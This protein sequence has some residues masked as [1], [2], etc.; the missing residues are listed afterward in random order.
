MFE[1]ILNL[2]RKKQESKS[3]ES[4]R[5]QEVKIISDREDLNISD[6]KFIA[7]YGPVI[8]KAFFEENARYAEIENEL[9]RAGEKP[10]AAGGRVSIY[11]GARNFLPNLNAPVPTNF[12]FKALQFLQN[13]SI[14]NPHISMAVENVVA[15]GNTDYKIDFGEIGEGQSTALRKL[16][17]KDVP[18][19]YEFSDGE[20][21]MDNDI[22]TQLAITGTISAESVIKKDLRGI[23]NIVRVDPYY[24]RF[25]YDPE[26]AVHIPLQEIGG[27]MN[28]INMTNT[29]YPGY[30]ELNPYTYFY[31]AM[32]R[33][34]EM[35]YAIPPFMAAIESILIEN[36]MIKNLQNMMR[37]LGM[38]GFLSV[39]VN[40]PPQRQGEN[41]STYNGRL[42]SYLEKLRPTV[43]KGFHR[44][45][46][47]GF[48]D[49]HEFKVHSPMNPAAAENTLKMVKSLIYAGVKQDPNMHGENYSV[50]ET[51][52]RVI[53]EKMTQQV[54]NYQRVLGTFKSKI[55]K[56]HLWLN[57]KFV[58][59]VNVKYDRS[60]VHD[61]KR[62]QEVLTQKITNTGLLYQAGIIDQTKRA[63]M[64]G[65]DEAA[66]DQPLE[67]DLLKI[68]KLKPQP[69][70]S[71]KKSNSKRIEEL[72]K[73]L[74]AS[75]PEFNY[76]VPEE[77]S[78]LSLVKSSDFHDKKLNKFLKTYLTAVNKQFVEAIDNAKPSIERELNRL[79][80]D[81][82]LSQVQ[83]AVIYG[84]FSKWDYN[85]IDP[86]TSIVQDNIPAIYS[87]FRKDKSVFKPEEGFSRESLFV[88]PD[89]IFELHD[90]RAIELL[91][92]I[93]RIYLGKFITDADTEK[94]FMKWIKEK[95]ESGDVPIGKNSSLISEFI[96]QFADTV[97]LEAWKIRRIIETTVNRTRNTG[98]V[99]YLNQAQ[100]IEYE[101]V[102]VMDDITCSWCKHMNSKKFSVKQSVDKYQKL[103]DNGVQSL[104]EFSPFATSIKLDE[105]VK[106]DAK[107]LQSAGID[108]PSY[109]CHCRGRIV[110][111]YQK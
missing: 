40:A 84:L 73:K 4:E 77:C 52:G 24:I 69:T 64:L 82:S 14:Y 105:F 104:P 39:L 88:I 30:I 103:F 3:V 67:T 9:A 62:D 95:F 2:F 16:L 23:Q 50:T 111:H 17:N 57:G 60:S 66:E 11:E 12:N 15:L 5:I 21:S 61:E 110:A 76:Y 56:L 33:Q 72:K 90:Y 13:L 47:L 49:T 53:M 108:I 54:S 28:G 86:T 45:V 48:K 8:Q 89:A 81:A 1:Y 26:K 68:A 97:A 41:E 109:H 31:I 51:F 78:P 71:K 25:A 106:M 100:I 96:S 27:L 87:Y 36:D 55:F 94:R 18:N 107:S 92:S 70:D 93:D 19:W 42:N 102:E 35:P 10:V 83:G 59:E 58:D 63:N 20:D 7:R 44:G 29:K 46:V 74:K 65:F 79:S 32:R 99:F 43:E 85:F 37:R 22:L 91:E 101:V 34:G 75:L 6:D 80:V 38:M 98:H